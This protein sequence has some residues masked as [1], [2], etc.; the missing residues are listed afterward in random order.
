MAQTGSFL[1][2]AAYCCKGALS[3]SQ[4]PYKL[5][6]NRTLS[7]SNDFER[8]PFCFLRWCKAIQPSALL[9]SRE[10]FS[11]FTKKSLMGEVYVFAHVLSSRE[12]YLLS[13]PALKQSLS[14]FN[15][16]RG[17]NPCCQAFGAD[18]PSFKFLFEG[19]PDH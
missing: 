11:M 13:R 18:L 6:T 3:F 5:F 2:E 14:T 9:F 15:A 4:G 19:L 1:F 7:F 8:R 16:L 10:R 12:P 17:A